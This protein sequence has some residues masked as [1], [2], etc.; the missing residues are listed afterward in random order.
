MMKVKLENRPVGP[1][2]AM[3]VGAA[4]NEKPTYTTVGAGGCA[5]L[6]PVL[7]V[8]LKNTHYIT[9]G[10]VKTGYFSVNIP[11]TAH[12]KEMDYCGM[13]SGNDVDKS[14]LFSSFYDAAGNAPM[15]EECPLNFLCKVEGSKE[16][17][18][19]TMFFGEIVAAY[20]GED[21]LTNGQPDPIK[22]D[23]IIMMGFSYCSLDKVIGQPFVEGKKLR[24]DHVI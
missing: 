8:S 7:C 19:F 13:V 17:R 9:Q 10:I 6:D 15:I 21:C 1:F 11:G 18:G 4:V 22:I 14:S 2:P 16:I 3:I 20:A 24:E 5:C 12:L 23:P